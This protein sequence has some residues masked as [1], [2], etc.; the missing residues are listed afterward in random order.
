MNL[1]KIKDKDTKTYF[2][3]DF[4]KKKKWIIF[5]NWDNCGFCHRIRPLWDNFVLNNRNINFAEIER[6]QFDNM[7]QFLKKRNEVIPHF[8]YFVEYTNE[9]N[10]TKKRVIDSLESYIEDLNKKKRKT[11]KR[12]KYMKKS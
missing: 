11:L 2:L 5:Y 3:K 9:K 8:P 12:K 1:I 10:I 4:K 6:S 7:K